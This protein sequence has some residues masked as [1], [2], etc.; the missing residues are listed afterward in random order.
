MGCRIRLAGCPERDFL[1]PVDSEARAGEMLRAFGTSV[2]DIGRVKH[3]SPQVWHELKREL[4]EAYR[5]MEES[6]FLSC[7]VIPQQ[8]LLEARE[9]SLTH[10]IAML[11]QGET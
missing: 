8:P 6:T 4:L 9:I 3:S 11:Y 1:L 5:C 2:V 10:G 7:R